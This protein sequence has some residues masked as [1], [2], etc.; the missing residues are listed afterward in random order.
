M[1]GTKAKRR[2]NKESRIAELERAMQAFS[3]T[4]GRDDQKLE[5]WQLLCDDCGV[6]SSSSIKKC[7]S[8]SIDQYMG[9]DQGSREW[10]TTSGGV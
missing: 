1:T 6:E 3:L 9:F 4:Y 2:A 7:S 10:T 8:N 5:K